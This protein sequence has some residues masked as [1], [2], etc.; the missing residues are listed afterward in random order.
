MALRI[1]TTEVQSIY[2]GTTEITEIYLDTTEI[3]PTGAPKL[4]IEDGYALLTESSD[5]ILLEAA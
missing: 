3:L 5:H 4:L 1:G 2:L